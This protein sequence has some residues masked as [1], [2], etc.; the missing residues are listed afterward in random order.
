MAD[1]MSALAAVSAGYLS[2]VKPLGIERIRDEASEKTVRASDITV[3]ATQIKTSAT[4][5][6]T[7]ATCPDGEN[8]R[9][10]YVAARNVTGGASTLAVY[11]VPDGGSSSTTLNAVFQG[12]IAAGATK[13][14]SE[15]VGYQLLPGERLTMNCTAD[16]DFIAFA[17]L[18]RITQGVAA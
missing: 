12:S 8:W 2:G 17:R 15:A 16:D 18:T 13:V 3:S 14:V 1:K 6:V 4:G 11:L 9:V 10:E 5:T 7:L